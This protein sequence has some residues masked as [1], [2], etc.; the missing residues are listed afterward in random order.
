MITDYQAQQG[1]H[2]NSD[3]KSTELQKQS[4]KL[5]IFKSYKGQS[6]QQFPLGFLPSPIPF[7]LPSD[8][9]WLSFSS[10]LAPCPW[11]LLPSSSWKQAGS[12][13]PFWGQH[14]PDA[15]GSSHKTAW[16]NFWSVWKDNVGGEGK[17]ARHFLSEQIE[18]LDPLYTVLSLGLL[19]TSLSTTRALFL[20]KCFFAEDCCS[21]MSLVSSW[22][23]SNI[24]LAILPFSVL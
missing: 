2:L 24:K 9:S 13:S 5:L 7:P 21:T 22:T 20:L 4:D 10:E 6:L 8:S 15:Q 16:P 23:S 14:P 3:I 12:S 1:S 11:V 17:H 18:G 19:L